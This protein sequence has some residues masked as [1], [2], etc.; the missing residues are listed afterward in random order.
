MN[1][2]APINVAPSTV[3]EQRKSIIRANA[4]QVEVM[5]VRYDS[6]AD[7]CRALGWSCSKVYRMIGENFRN[8]KNR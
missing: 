7:A 1:W 8:A 5:G 3:A 2:L 6:I 4:R